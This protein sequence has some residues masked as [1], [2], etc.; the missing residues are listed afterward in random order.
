MLSLVCV[1]SY[2]GGHVAVAMVSACD[3]A[4]CVSP[5]QTDVRSPACWPVCIFTFQYLQNVDKYSMLQSRLIG[6]YCSDYLKI[7][8]ILS[9][10]SIAPSLLTGRSRAWVLCCVHVVYDLL[11]GN[12]SWYNWG[13]SS[14]VKFASMMLQVDIFSRCFT[15]LQW[16]LYCLYAVTELFTSE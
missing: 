12:S 15:S 6:S 16:F 4:H 9:L 11:F 13:F 10:Q 7:F 5:R 1:I 2:C 14:S 3:P 8:G